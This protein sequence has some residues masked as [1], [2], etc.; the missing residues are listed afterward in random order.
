MAVKQG[1]GNLESLPVELSAAQD[2]G[3]TRSKLV[4]E[5]TRYRAGERT[6]IK[7]TSS[8]SDKSFQIL[9]T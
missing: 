9:I 8:E 3:W 5:H 6:S 7:S 4:T 1:G 2:V